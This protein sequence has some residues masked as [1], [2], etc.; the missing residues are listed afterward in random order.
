MTWTQQQVAIIGGSIT[1]MPTPVSPSD[2]AIKSYVDGFGAQ[3]TNSLGADVLLNNVGTYFDG[4][5]VAQGTHG[6]WF[7]SGQVTVRDNAGVA[8][9]SAKLWDGTTVISSGAASIP[10]AGEVAVIALSG[11]LA[12]PAGNLRISVNDPTS[13]SGFIKFNQSGNS[14]DS[15][16]T[17]FRV[18]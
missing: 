8:T 3:L 17:A 12:S 10:A 14:K 11:F 16:I 6:T 9:I 5:S 15:T 18:G 13:T 7:A 2:V 1:G 4:P